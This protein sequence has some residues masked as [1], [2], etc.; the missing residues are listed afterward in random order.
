MTS[1]ASGPVLPAVRL[2]PL[3]DAA[4]ECPLCH[5]A[6]EVRGW[7]MPGMRMLAD[8]SCPGCGREFYGDLPSGHG[9][10][11]PA[12]LDRATGEVY[13]QETLTV[14]ADFL[15]SSFALRVSEP[16]GLQVEELRKVR[17]PVVLL[18]CLDWV[19]GHAL[20][21]LLNAQYYL[22]RADELDL[23][24]LVPR[25]LRWMVPE[26]AAAVWTVDLPVSRGSEWNDWLAGELHRRVEALGECHLSLAFSHP[27]PTDFRIERFTRVAPFPLERWAE[28]AA[29]PVVTFIWRGD[30][31]W[32]PPPARSV[33]ARVRRGLRRLVG[34]PPLRDRS[35]HAVIGL[36]ERLREA[37][38]AVD[39]AVAGL[40]VEGSFPAW[41][42]DLRTSRID[43]QVERSWCERYARSH[44][45]VGVHGS[46]MLLPSAH[47]GAMIELVPDNPWDNRWG[48]IVQDVLVRSDDVRDALFRY[49]FLAAETSPAQ[50]ARIAASL[51]RLQPVATLHFGP[52]ATDHA[53]VARDWPAVPGQFAAAS[54]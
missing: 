16:V 41:I 3:P 46:N 24:V 4:H 9:L 32:A 26:G 5:G 7:Y 1:V 18:N 23:I 40:G 53:L 27:H 54:P 10:P 2:H 6:L 19:Y 52:G 38:P 22:D 29:S 25:Y 51:I 47:A 45:V 30:R 31:G 44:L 17:R 21:K 8:L 43:A 13:H 48:N 37:L 20:L 49:R 35:R 50:V 34:L 42:E 33:P 11:H 12:L 15:R 28:T 14:F 36:A 39:F